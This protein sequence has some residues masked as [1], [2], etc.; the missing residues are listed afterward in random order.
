M[1]RKTKAKKE[2]EAKREI[3]DM[4]EATNL[5]IEIFRLRCIREYRTEGD[6]WLHEF[7]KLLTDY[8]IIFGNLPLN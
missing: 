4:K 3:D 8:I 1:S 6:Y 5:R 2:E 7:S